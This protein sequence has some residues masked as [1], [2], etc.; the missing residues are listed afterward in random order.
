MVSLKYALELLPTRRDEEAAP[1][2]SGEEGWPPADPPKA[3]A[4]LRSLRATC[5]RMFAAD[6]RRFSTLPFKLVWKMGDY[7]TWSC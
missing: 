5:T 1:I 4:E 3:G 6:V 7:I 2:G